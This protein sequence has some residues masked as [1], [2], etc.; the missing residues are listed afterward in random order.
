VRLLVRHPH[1]TDRACPPRRCAGIK[2][3][4]LVHVCDAKLG[5]WSF[6]ATIYKSQSYCGFVGYEDASPSNVS[7]FVHGAEMRWQ[8]P[9]RLT[10]LCTRAM[11][12]ASA[13]SK[14]S[15]RSLDSQA[16]QLILGSSHGLPMERQ[17]NFQRPHRPTSP[18]PNHP[19]TP[20][21]CHT[22]HVIR[23]RLLRREDLARS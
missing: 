14:R 6:K 9:A 13:R 7:A 1:W 18:P 12:S 20:A 10:A 15:H 5:R 2:V 4:A 23:D 8:R 17:Q 19:A 3:Q 22:G 16:Q 11:V 21:R